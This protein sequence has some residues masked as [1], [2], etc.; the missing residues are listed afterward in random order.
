MPRPERG[1][2]KGFDIKMPERPVTLGDYLD[3][4]S[5]D[6]RQRNEPAADRF[7]DAPAPPL[8][9][10]PPQAPLPGPSPDLK[11]IPPAQSTLAAPTQPPA[12]SEPVVRQPLPPQSAARRPGASRKQINLTPET[13]RMLDELLGD[14]RSRSAERDIRASEVLHALVL[15][16]Y[17]TR[18]QLDLSAVG[19]RGQWGSSS[20]AAL[21]CSLRDAFRRALSRS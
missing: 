1:L 13:L 18:A 17:E 15:L 12:A 6:R 5:L 20:A 16:A 14:F 4:D 7:A 3:D 10:A 21:P 8:A 2:P 19:P 9:P 11:H